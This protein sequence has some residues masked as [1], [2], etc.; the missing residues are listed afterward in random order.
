MTGSRL[1]QFPRIDVWAALLL[2]SF[3]LR[4]YADEAPT[5]R[6]IVSLANPAQHLVHVKIEMSAGGDEHDLQLPVWNALYQIRDFSQYVNWIRAKNKAGEPLAVHLLDKSRWHVAGTAQGSEVEYEMFANTPEPFGAQLDA[7]HAFFNLAEVL[8]YPVDLRSSPIQLQFVDIPAGWRA[9]MALPGSGGEFAAENYDRLVDAPVEIGAFQESD[10][11]QGGGHYRVVLDADPADAD[12][13]K[14]V[15]MDRKIAAAETA[16]MQDRPFDTYLFLYHLPRH[17][18]GG[19]M[20]H[21]KS[22]AIDMSSSRFAEDPQL[23]ARVTAHEFFHLW[24][25][26]RIRP[27]SLEPVDYAK[28]NYTPSLWFSEGVT[29]T[30]ADI[31]VYR[32]GL[33]DESAVLRD[34]AEQIQELQQRPARLTQ[35]VEESSLD[36][37]LEKYDYYFQPQRS[38]SYYN[39]GQMVGTLL[40]LKIRDVS[41][42]TMS[43]RDVFQWLNENYARQGKFFPDS[44]GIRK[45]AE[46]LTGTNFEE[47]FR[48]YVSGTDEIPWDDFFRSVGLHVAQSQAAVADLG[49]TP[50]RSTGG[51]ISVGSVIPNSD[52]EKAGLAEGDSI[53]QFNGQAVGSGVRQRLRQ[54]RPGDTLTLKIHNSSGDHDVQWK[55]AG[56]LEVEFELKDVD[57]VT[58]QQKARRLAW[59]SG[60]SQILGEAGK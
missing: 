7:R 44:E 23:M 16:W 36:C 30:V 59:L 56:R 47:F 12:I 29:S 10:F 26:K 32:A 2:L 13:Q 19:G 38:I 48:K 33:L 5:L 4:C 34:I 51:A 54:L 8:M 42:G 22:T 6:Y 17:P 25:V 27:Q 24:N 21:A 20:E 52:A 18:A 45:A 39:K 41:H 50:E 40:D 31:V 28:E 55:L 60:E 46:T 53:V 14:L 43:L 35:S 11:D 37:W 1:P 58:S 49:F 9:A 3:G 15:S 57:N